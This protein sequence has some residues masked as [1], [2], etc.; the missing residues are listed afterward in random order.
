MADA[1][2]DPTGTFLK[3]LNELGLD[4]EQDVDPL[5]PLMRQA[6]VDPAEL[7]EAERSEILLGLFAELVNACRR[8][9]L[10][11]AK[12]IAEAVDRF[13][14]D[15]AAELTDLA[16]SFVA[17]AAGEYRMA[18]ANASACLRRDHSH[19]QITRPIALVQRATHRMRLGLLDAALNDL[20]EAE[21]YGRSL[22]S[23]HGVAVRALI[24]WWR[25]DQGQAIDA[26]EQGPRFLSPGVDF[27][28][29]WYALAAELVK[30]GQ[31]FDQDLSRHTDCLAHEFF[32][33]RSE[34][35]AGAYVGTLGPHVVR[36]G[37][38]LG[39]DPSALLEELD[40]GADSET[41]AG[42]AYQWC[43]A[44]ATSD[45]DRL[46]EIA[47][48]HRDGGAVLSAI[49]GYRDAAACAQTDDVRERLVRRSRF[50][51]DGLSRAVKAPTET[52]LPYTVARELTAAEQDVVSAV[53][54]GLSNEDAADL[55]HCSV[56]TIESHLASAYRKLGVKRR[57]QLA[58][59][60]AQA[61]V[62]DQ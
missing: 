46:A 10:D 15:F 24:H 44:L 51:Y 20:D 23:L 56:R 53:A 43:L 2:D 4:P 22:M 41:A 55:L 33:A 30:N 35:V 28:V 52:A 26:L 7:A 21:E 48:G 32:Q 36:H 11:R 62:S 13:S 42:M 60:I 38:A 18:E 14:V 6:E 59:L 58:V 61:N 50:L 57:T 31:I 47:D 3:Y 27:G 8:A 9:H 12:T 17:E 37:M 40:T 39:K 34:H 49:Q 5:S 54:G 16:R 19:P 29:G 25:G 1:I 45:S